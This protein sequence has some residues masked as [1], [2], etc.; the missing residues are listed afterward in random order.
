VSDLSSTFNISGLASGLDTN[1]IVDQLMAIERVPETRIKNRQAAE[2]ARQQ[3]LRDIQTR[4]QTLQDAADGLQDV[5]A[6]ANTQSVTVS[7]STKLT[8]SYVSGAGPG[9]YQVSVTQMARASQHWFTYT[10]PSGA[11]TITIGG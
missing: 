5:G 10:P 1:S 2:N 6:W 9:G 7:D 8:A 11:D 3:A 4:L